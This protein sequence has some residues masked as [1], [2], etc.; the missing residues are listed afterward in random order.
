MGQCINDPYNCPCEDIPCN[1]ILDSDDSDAQ[2]AYKKC[3]SEMDYCKAQRKQGIEEMEKQ[4]K[5]IESSCRQ[6]FSL[7]DCTAIR[8][9]TGRQEC[10]TAVINAKKQAQEEMEKQ[11]KEIETACRKDL[12]LCNCDS[13]ENPTGKKECENALIQ[14]KYQAEEERNKVINS[15]YSDISN[16]DCSPIENNEGKLECEKRL[17]EAK[18]FK[19]KIQTA[20][21][22][23]PLACDCNEIESPAGRKE[24][25]TKKKEAFDEITNKIRGV[26]SKCFKD[27]A[28]C[29]CSKI[30]IPA[31][32]PESIEF[33]DIQKEYGLKCKYEGVYCEKLE[34][35]EIY[36]PGMP[37][38]LGTFFAKEY[39][40][41]IE[42]EKEKGMQE[43]GK[44]ITSCI[45]TPEKCECEKTP[46][47]AN[48]FCEKMKNLQIRC[49]DN[50]YSACMM[51]DESKNLPENMPYFMISPLEKMTQSLRD[52]KEKIM[53]GRASKQVGDMILDC[54]DDTDK[55]DCSMSPTGQIQAFCEHKI[56]LVKS[57]KNNKNF[58]SCFILDEEPITD[59]VIPD[60]V[61]IY[62]EKN[63][64]P[65]IIEKK[66][67]MFNEMKID[68]ICESAKTI[69]DCKKIYESNLDN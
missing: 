49:Y 8:S 40:S 63:V 62:I 26:L 29:D 37:P 21:K 41:Y 18:E 32:Y 42:K 10:E 39:S 64:E 6:D 66:N 35:T 46:T 25:E 17:T 5:E 4:R 57:C 33:C 69:P 15:C 24:C 54:M 7:C 30:G 11:K 67:N 3:I 34:D 58:D 9:P 14:A 52:A 68:T 2:R 56:N 45:N 53:K 50:D 65:K 12:S 13:V 28:N 47:Y 43:A 59:D 1:Q 36:P 55:C 16:C 48:A 60:F 27:V 51:L 38:W 61:R 20:C 31:E 22:T 19:E 44:I 23:N